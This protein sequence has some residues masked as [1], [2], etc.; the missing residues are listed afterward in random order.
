MTNGEGLTFEEW[1]Y[2]AK[3]A[4]AQKLF[5]EELVQPAMTANLAIYYGVREEWN[6]WAR[7]EDPA[8]WKQEWE[9][10]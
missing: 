5:A 2:A 10:T 1:L 8:E 3:P 4:R 7:G 6:A 9:A